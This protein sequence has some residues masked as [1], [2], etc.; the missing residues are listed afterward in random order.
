M[1]TSSPLGR[2]T[3]CKCTISILALLQ[4]LVIL[5]V[6]LSPGWDTCPYGG[7]EL[8][9]DLFPGVL[10]KVCLD[11]TRL[12][13][14]PLQFCTEQSKSAMNMGK[15]TRL[16]SISDSFW[17]MLVYLPQR[18]PLHLSDLL[19]KGRRTSDLDNSPQ[20]FSTCLPSWLLLPPYYEHHQNQDHTL[21]LPCHPI[22]VLPP[23]PTPHSSQVLPST[24]GV[25]TQISAQR[26]EPPKYRLRALLCREPMSFLVPP[27]SLYNRECQSQWTQSSSF[28]DTATSL[29][30]EHYLLLST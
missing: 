26:T 14:L 12:W 19:S 25:L 3:G 17:H 24:L 13:D 8:V 9:L 23:C 22:S 29:L 30:K 21:S 18:T 4:E 10:L 5:W 6:T 16:F 20:F 28:L 2:N 27:G 11:G 7:H 1:S 15:Q